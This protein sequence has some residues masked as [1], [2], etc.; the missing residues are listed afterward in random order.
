M[1]AGLCNVVQLWTGWERLDPYSH[2]SGYCVSWI[3]SDVVMI[4]DR[5][6]NY[7]VEH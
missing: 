3:Y 7:R 6:N 1:K 5:R 4:S 2:H